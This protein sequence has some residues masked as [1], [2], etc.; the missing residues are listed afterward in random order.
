M[1]GQKKYHFLPFVKKVG[2]IYI[3]HLLIK[4]IEENI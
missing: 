1:E 2:Y 4:F 3:C